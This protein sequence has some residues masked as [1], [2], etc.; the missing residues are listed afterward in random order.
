MKYILSL[1]I[2]LIV[3]SCN[4]SQKQKKIKEETAVY[5]RWF[6][7]KIELPQTTVNDTDC[8]NCTQGIFS[9]RKGYMIISIFDIGCSSCM[10]TLDNW[11]E[12]T[13]LMN[14]RNVKVAFIIPPELM[15]MYNRQKQLFDG[16]TLY[17]DKKYRFIEANQI[18]PDKALQT[19][20]ID[21]T[22]KIVILGNPVINPGVRNI[23]LKFTAIR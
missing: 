12:F 10:E 22:N 5:S 14:K 9:D 3:F 23:Y 19:F 16:L 11:K 20:L 18:S 4:N 8:I 7:K 15:D 17:F 6:N 2:C 13:K 1:L 21:K